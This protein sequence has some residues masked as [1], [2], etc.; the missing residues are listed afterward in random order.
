MKGKGKYPVGGYSDSTG[1]FKMFCRYRSC[2]NDISGDCKTCEHM[3]KER[4]A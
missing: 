4:I 2:H 1:A 3:T